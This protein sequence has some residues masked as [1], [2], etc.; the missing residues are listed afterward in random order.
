MPLYQAYFGRPRYV[1]LRTED[2][3]VLAI[4]FARHFFLILLWEGIKACRLRRFGKLKYT[5]PASCGYCNPRA[6]IHELPQS[7]RSLMFSW[8][9]ARGLWQR[10]L[11]ICLLPQCTSRNARGEM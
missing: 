6:V 3:F 4:R 5:T 8:I 1:G 2:W 7:T 11:Q 9:A 10:Y